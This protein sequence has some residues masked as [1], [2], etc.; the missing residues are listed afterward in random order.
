MTIEKG[1]EILYWMFRELKTLSHGEIH[2]ILKVRDG[3]VALIEKT[4]L[5][6]EKPD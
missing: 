2:I 1:K 5:V 6:K 4:K 3:K